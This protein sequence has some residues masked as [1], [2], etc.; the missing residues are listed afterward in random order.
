[1]RSSSAQHVQVN[2]AQD[3]KEPGLEIRAGLK[4]PLRS[5]GA[6]DRFLSQVLSRLP[7][8]SQRPGEAEQP[9]PQ[10]HDLSGKIALVLGAPFTHSGGDGPPPSRANR[11]PR[12]PKG[13]P[14]AWQGAH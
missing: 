3:S 10:V 11:Y 5:E 2:V 8:A 13:R 14:V 9:R 4:S 1:M 12:V 6:G 7:G